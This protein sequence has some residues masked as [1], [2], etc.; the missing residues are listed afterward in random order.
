MY[1]PIYFLLIIF[2]ISTIAQTSSSSLL[3]EELSYSIGDISISG[4]LTLP[5]RKTHHPA[6][7]LISGG[8]PDNRDA[9]IMGF[10]P[11]R[12]LAEEFASAGYAVFR[13]DDRSIGKSTGEHPWQ[14]TV[15]ELADDILGAID[16]LKK[17][18]NIDSS[19]IGLCGHSFGAIISPYLKS[20]APE[21]NFIISIAGYA[22]TFETQWL[23]YRRHTL[24]LSAIPESEIQGIVN[25]DQLMMAISRDKNERGRVSSNLKKLAL[26]EYNNLSPEDKLIFPTY[27]SYKFNSYYGAFSEMINTDFAQSL[28]DYYP[29]D[30]YSSLDCPIL[31]VLAEKDDSV[32]IDYHK[33]LIEEAISGMPY[34]TI[35]TIPEANHYMTYDYS[36]EMKF[37]DGFVST[38]K[39]WLTALKE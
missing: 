19:K 34:A 2:A 14:Y 18:P 30:Y 24:E 7:I 33:P 8:Y 1:Y 32:P 3:E 20:K 10:K 17:H 25:H 11:F 39:D 5:N 31:F 13:F 35:V 6:I 38:L 21:I 36:T 12:I 9:E 15:Y 27:D 4:T 26:S 28:L 16:E 37:V 23:E 29:V 22:T